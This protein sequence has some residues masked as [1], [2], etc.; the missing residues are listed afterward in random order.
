MNTREM[1]PF[2]PNLDH[3]L[4]EQQNMGCRMRNSH[5][6]RKSTGVLFSSRASRTSTVP[7][8]WCAAPV[9]RLRA[10]ERAG[11]SGRIEIRRTGYPEAKG[12][13]TVFVTRSLGCRKRDAVRSRLVNIGVQ[14]P[15]ITERADTECL[16]TGASLC[17][18]PSRQWDE[19]E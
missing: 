16:T 8:H 13:I 18:T 14:G 6:T 1:R 11:H 15:R 12:R 17:A 4:A 5:K 7:L 2:R 10:V 19:A 3:H 9:P